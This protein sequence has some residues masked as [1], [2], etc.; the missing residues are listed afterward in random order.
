MHLFD[1]IT[2]RGLDISNRLWLAPMCQYSAESDGPN[3][4]RP[5]E[6]HFQHYGSRALGGFGL[7]TVEAT[8]ITAQ[9]RISPHCLVLNND[10]D[11]PAFAKLAGLIE[12]G[13]AV[14]AIQI[15]HAGRK[16][17]SQVPW[18]GRGSVSVSDGGWETIA[19]SAIG[20]DDKLGTPREMTAAE[21][22]DTISQF[23]RS[24]KLAVEAG[25]KAIELHGAHGYLMHQFL[26]PVSNR[27]EDEWGGDFAGRTRFFSDVV[28]AVRE[29]IGDV[30][31]IARI[32]ATDWLEETASTHDGS[33]GWKVAETIRLVRELPEVDF[34]NVS[35][36]GNVPV[37]IPTGPG[38]QVPFSR[39]IKEETGASTGVAGLIAN[40]TQAGVVVHD[41]H[42]DVVYIGRV[43]LHHPY[44]ARQWAAQMGEPVTW[45]NQ[46][47][48][49]VN[50][51]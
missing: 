46:Y 22:T 6:W 41:E 5:N 20:Y 49:G 33:E 30:P 38:Y 21:I 37:R 50:E 29:A 11:V 51:R 16:G 47:L 27:R 18:E 19:P 2:I 8:G 23:A 9:G 12:A 34:W 44:I 45:P 15:G 13:G 35:T 40:A 28:R 7:V 32:S 26:S 10:A 36:G 14:P 24:A 42:A 48:R 39:R 3:L 4:G 1:P 25:F 17:S 43:A 31:L